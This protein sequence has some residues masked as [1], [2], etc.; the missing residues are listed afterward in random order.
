MCRSLPFLRLPSPPTTI[1]IIVSPSRQGDPATPDCEVTP[2]HDESLDEADPLSVT[3]LLHE[4]WPRYALE[5]KD[6]KLTHHLF[7]YQANEEWRVG[8]DFA[9]VRFMPLFTAERPG[10]VR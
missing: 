2:S 1:I 8:T 10:A 7:R 5:G 9:P 4:G 6:G 3:A